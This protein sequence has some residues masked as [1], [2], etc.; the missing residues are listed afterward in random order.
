MKDEITIV[1][2]EQK[3]TK[4]DIEKIKEDDRRFERERMIR[5]SKE[6]KKN[7]HKR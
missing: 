1:S 6:I 7:E 4:E 3:L 5:I 2:P